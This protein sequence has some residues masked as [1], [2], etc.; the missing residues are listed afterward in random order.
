MIVEGNHLYSKA[1][2][3]AV[4]GLRAGQTVG[5]PDFEAARERL[6]ATGA[7]DTVGYSYAPDAKGKGYA[8]KLYG[9]P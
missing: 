4:A 9:L 5:K 1:Q 3:L 2:V 7:F 8:A 6:L